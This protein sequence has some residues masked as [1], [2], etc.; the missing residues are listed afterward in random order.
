MS[1]HRESAGK[2]NYIRDKGGL[3]AEKKLT[4][5]ELDKVG[6]EDIELKWDNKQKLTALF[7][8]KN[9]RC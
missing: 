5:E 8:Q 3:M 1:L 9:Y 7:H 2:G 6:I 4:L